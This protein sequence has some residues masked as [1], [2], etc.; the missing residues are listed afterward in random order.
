MTDPSVV[1]YPSIAIDDDGLVTASNE[2]FRAVSG[3][4]PVGQSVDALF[5]AHDHVP[6][7]PAELVAALGEGRTIRLVGPTGSTRFHARATVGDGGGLLVL[8]R[9]MTEGHGKIDLDLLAK[10]VDAANNSIVVADLSDEE[11]PL[12][13][14]NEGFTQLTGYSR[15]D[16]IG[17]NCRFL[18]FRDGV[19]DCEGAEQEEALKVLRTTVYG[20]R[21]ASGVVLRNY[22]KSGELFYN[23]LYLTPVHDASGRA[24]HIIGVQNDVTDRVLQAQRENELAGRL[25]EVFSA[26][27]VP[28]GIIGLHGETWSQETAN[29]AAGILGL[30]QDHD[31]LDGLPP[32]RALPWRSALQ[33]VKDSN[34]P[35]RFDTLT[36]DGRTFEVLVSPI[37]GPDGQA[38]Y[39]AADVSD[40]R[41]AVEDLL[42]V[43]NRQLKRIAQDIH[44]GVGQLL[45]G[46]SMLAA[47][48][49]RDLDGHGQEDAASHL[50]E[51]LTRSL[52]KLRSFALGLDPSDIDQISM[53]TA[54]RRLAGE[55]EDIL[56]AQVYLDGDALDLPFQSEVKMDLYRIAQEAV[57]NAV[58]HGGAHDIKL[59]ARRTDTELRF[60]VEDD[61]S[62]FVSDTP[63]SGMGL[64]SM[65][66]RAKRHGGA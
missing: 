12:C 62:G 16:V 27:V 36:D 2:L 32:S 39:V 10:A 53:R 17:R 31:I 7:R 1:P 50:Q 9:L 45:V 59:L 24:T 49:V 14:V 60:D 55:A 5:D 51:L 28:I 15:E 38:L 22:K 44:D 54:L 64:R 66:A 26:S 21:L 20:Q 57:T 40:V 63:A 4:D 58:R 47:A 46:A 3:I 52:A 29:D 23:E 30:G 41:A 19:R 48:L 34:A 37:E 25:R 11:H 43:S 56:G 18:Q 33:F 13:Y 8:V 61:G 6:S 42:Y 65:R 35:T